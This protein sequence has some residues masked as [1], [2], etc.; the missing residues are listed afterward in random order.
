MIFGRV[1]GLQALHFLK[2]APSLV[3]ASD[4][5][6][7]PLYARTRNQNSHMTTNEELRPSNRPAHAGRLPLRIVLIAAARSA[8][9]SCIPRKCRAAPGNAQVEFLQQALGEP[10]A[11]A[12]LT[13]TPDADTVVRLHQNGYSL[14][15][16]AVSVG[17][18]SID[19]GSGGL[20][21]HT[22]GVSRRTAYGWEAVTVTPAKTEQFLTVVERQGHKTWRWQL[23]SLNLTP[24]VGDDGAVG[25][26]RNGRL[27]SDVA[28]VE[29]V[30]MLDSSASD[31]TPRRPLV[32]RRA[33]TAAGASSSPSTTRTPLPY[34]IDPAIPPVLRSRRRSTPAARHRFRSPTRPASSPA[35]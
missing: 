28:Y 4:A 12:P 24:R 21:R 2:F 5:R 8:R 30:R 13:R 31:I 11:A 22:N 16:G 18:R 33:K 17:L 35:T 25:F 10:A 27:M 6:T 20:D 15:R 3:D 19:S 7:L 9:R 23:K 14:D 26:I 1:Y 32:G 29:P 34:V